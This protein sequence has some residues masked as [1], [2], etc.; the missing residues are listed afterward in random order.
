MSYVVYIYVYAE[1]KCTGNSP[2]DG[3]ENGSTLL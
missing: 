1:G 2:K 3:G